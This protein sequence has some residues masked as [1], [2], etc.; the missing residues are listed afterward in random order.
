[1][2]TRKM[3]GRYRKQSVKRKG[4]HW[5]SRDICN[6]KRNRNPRCMYPRISHREN[7]QKSKDRERNVR[8]AGM[9]LPIFSKR[10]NHHSRNHHPHPHP[11]IGY[12]HPCSNSTHTSRWP[13]NCRKRIP[14]VRPATHRLR[15]G[16]RGSPAC[17]ASIVG[18]DWR[19]HEAPRVG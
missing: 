18:G 12:P 4:E 10:A 5:Y 19:G 17:L 1:M 11:S 3:M 2:V 15:L 16:L 9:L 13:S 7:E 6:V 14:V 8:V